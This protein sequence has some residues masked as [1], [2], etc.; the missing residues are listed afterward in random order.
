MTAIRVAFALSA[1]CSL[2]ALDAR[3]SVAE[4]YR[5]WCVSYPAA[6]VKSCTFTSFEQCMMTAGPGTG[7]VCVQNPWYLRY[8]PSGP[9]TADRPHHFRPVGTR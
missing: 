2:T 1:V 8:G 5:P 3:S 7:G 9:S 6:T 4:I